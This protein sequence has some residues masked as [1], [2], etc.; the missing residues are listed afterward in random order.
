MQCTKRAYLSFFAARLFELGLPGGVRIRS[1]CNRIAAEV[2]RVVHE[3]ALLINFPKV[4]SASVA[5]RAN[6]RRR[7]CS[8]VLAFMYH[9]FGHVPRLLDWRHYRHVHYGIS[10]AH[11][12]AS[13]LLESGSFSARDAS[14]ALICAASRW[15]FRLPPQY[16]S[17]DEANPYPK[18]CP[19]TDLG[20]FGMDASEDPALY[21]ETVSPES[22]IMTASA[23]FRLP[24]VA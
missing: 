17:F 12:H 16:A 7:A 11:V 2:L 21:E 13:I 10:A 18:E 14:L 9:T 6:T 24:S 1:L 23:A 19:K 15:Q 8:S 4:H 3:Y 22:P 20:D 5:R